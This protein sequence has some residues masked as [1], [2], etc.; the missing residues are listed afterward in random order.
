[1]SATYADQLDLL[2]AVAD[3]HRIDSDIVEAVIRA[4][5]AAHDGVIDAGRVRTV[6]RREHPRLRPQVVGAVYSGLT[7][8]GVIERVDERR[9]DDIRSRNRNKTDAIYRLA[10]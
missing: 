3:A 8:S 1:M 5:A 6:L 10:T 9:S 7:R 4:D 2:D